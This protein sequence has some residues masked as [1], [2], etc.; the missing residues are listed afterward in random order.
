MA[1]TAYF[2]HSVPPYRIDLNNQCYLALMDGN[3]VVLWESQFHSKWAEE[4]V[5]E[6]FRGY[7]PDPI[8]WEAFNT[9]PINNTQPIYFAPSPPAASPLTSERCPWEFQEYLSDCDD[10][11]DLNIG[12][13][14]CYFNAGSTLIPNDHNDDENNNNIPKDDVRISISNDYLTN[15]GIDD[16]TDNSIDDSVS[17]DVVRLHHRDGHTRNLRDYRFGDWRDRLK[18][19]KSFERCFLRASVMCARPPVFHDECILE[20]AAFHAACCCIEER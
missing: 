16:T 17:N 13:E 2:P 12:G 19:D 9:T 8:E 4:R 14:N 7:D 6:S 18:D 3:G 5:E 1:S 11:G 10:Y 15:Y 20:C